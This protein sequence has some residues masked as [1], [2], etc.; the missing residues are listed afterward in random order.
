MS[1]WIKSIIQTI[2]YPG[3]IS[4]MFIENVFPPIPSELIMPFAGY[5]AGEGS[6]N[7]FGVIAAGS[8]G[9]VIGALPLYY[10]G[11]KV[12]EEKLIEWANKY[13]RWLLLSGKDIERASDWFDRHGTTTVFLCRLVPGLRSL[14]SIPAGI[15]N[16]NIGLFLLLTTAGTVIWSTLL[17]WLGYELGT[18]YEV[19]GEY[20]DPIS[21]IVFGG[22]ILWYAYKVI[23]YKKG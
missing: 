8:C 22:F 2:G 16:M 6:L 14:I 10:L 12:G 11:Q 18:R 17:T 5:I 23:W 9:A 15:Q 13:G 20:L 21:Y 19:V 7:I 1:E 4:L 3:I